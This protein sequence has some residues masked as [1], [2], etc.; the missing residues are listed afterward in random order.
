MTHARTATL[1]AGLSSLVIGLGHGLFGVVGGAVALLLLAAGHGVLLWRSEALVLARTTHLI[2]TRTSHPILVKMV[3]RLARQAG[4]PSARVVLIQSELPNAF[5]MVPRPGRVS[6][7]LTRG[8]VAV[9]RRDELAGVI[10]HELAHARRCDARWLTLSAFA[11]GAGAALLVQAVLAL[12][13]TDS[14]SVAGLAAYGAAA[15]NAVLLQ[16]AISRRCELAADAA[17]AELCGSPLWIAA[18]LQHLEEIHPDGG[19]RQFRM[20]Y[21]AATRLLGAGRHA[22]ADLFSTHPSTSERL[23]RLWSMAGVGDTWG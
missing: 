20:P 14:L 21:P 8:L 16:M 4:L 10:A 23:R 22:L 3:E 6:I 15:A 12:L 1:L 18:A 2:A 9:L 11:A 7:A 19:G 5:A 17:G 13:D